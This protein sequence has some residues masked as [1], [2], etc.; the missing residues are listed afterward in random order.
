MKNIVKNYLSTKISQILLNLSGIAN[1]FGEKRNIKFTGFGEKRNIKFASFGEKRNI[2]SG[3]FGEKRNIT[4]L[5]ATIRINE[6]LLEQLEKIANDNN[7]STNKLI[8]N[9][10]EFALK[11][12][13]KSQEKS[14]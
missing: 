2:N 10:I 3:N 12:M 11:N 4:N 13:E 5:I 6:K 8:I 9:C 1:T 14:C 7:I